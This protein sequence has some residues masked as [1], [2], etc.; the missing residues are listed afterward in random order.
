MES[1][2]MV[3]NLTKQGVRKLEENG[4]F[5]DAIERHED[6]SG[7]VRKKVPVKD[8]AFYAEMIWGI[9]EHAGIIEP[10]E[11]ANI[12]KRKIKLINQQYA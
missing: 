4:W 8:L 3:V 9:G 10:M 2:P 11:A 1:V 5:A 12:I 6:G 7:T